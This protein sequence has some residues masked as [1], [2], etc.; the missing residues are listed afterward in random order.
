VYFII[1]Q[2]NTFVAHSFVNRPI[3]V[4]PMLGM[5]LG[6]VQTGLKLGAQL[7]LVFMGITTIGGSLPSDVFLAGTLVGAFVIGAG[8]AL[9]QATAL[10]VAVGLVSAMFEMMLRIIVATGIYVPIFDRFA[11]EG[12]DKAYEWF[13]YIGSFI[14]RIPSTLLV[15]AA[16]YFGADA[17][18]VAMNAIPTFIQGGISVASGMLPAIGLGLLMQMLWTTKMSSTFSSVSR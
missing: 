12:N 3:V 16:I 1:T 7:E 14:L 9:D 11:D 4:V 17:V 6:D 5:A 15:F 10:A 2:I 13:A 18:S 8:V